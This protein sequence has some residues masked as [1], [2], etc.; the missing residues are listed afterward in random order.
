MSAVTALAG[1][2]FDTTAVET[3]DHTRE[4]RELVDQLGRRSF[5]GLLGH[6]GRPERFDAALWQQLE[7]TGL[8]RL[9]SDPDADAGPAE[10]AVVLYGL[11]RHAAAVPIAETDVLAAWLGTRCGVSLPATGPLTVAIGTADTST[12]QITGTANHVPWASISAV[13]LIARANDRLYTGLIDDSEIRHGHNLAGEPRDAVQFTAATT[14]LHTLDEATHAELQRRGAWARC[15][16]MLGALDATAALTVTH[17]RERVQFGRSLSGFQSVQHA[18]AAMAGQIERA[19]AAASLAVAAAED[20]GFDSPRTDFAVTVCKTVMGRAAA[21]V[22]TI[23][24]QLH[25]AIGVTAEHPLS[26][27]TTRLR[28]WSDEFGTTAAH[29]RSLGRAAL[30]AESPWDLSIGN[31]TA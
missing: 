12:G 23:A 18:L 15:M 11:A 17:T 21:E 14:H 6:R 9:T 24:H 19:R 8:A 28:S 25:G 20:D 16:Q 5:D 3:D 7:K 22:T 31:F 30:A 10:L 29:A 13:L 1:G 27:F 26:L 2:I 4:L